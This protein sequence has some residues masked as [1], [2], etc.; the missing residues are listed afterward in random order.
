MTDCLL[1]DKVTGVVV[2]SS[3]DAKWVLQGT[4]DN[5]VEASRVINSRS[6][7]GKPLLETS[8]PKVIWKKNPLL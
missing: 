1:R 7:K 2:D 6:S 8:T 3:G 5:K 4:W